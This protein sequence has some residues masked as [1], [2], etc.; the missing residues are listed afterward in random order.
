MRAPDAR[1]VSE[2]LGFEKPERRA[3]V[4]ERRAAVAWLGCEQEAQRAEDENRRSACHNEGRRG[5]KE[6]QADRTATGS[7]EAYRVHL[8]ALGKAIA[9]ERALREDFKPSQRE[10][11][12]WAWLALLEQHYTNSG[13]ALRRW[14]RSRAAAGRRRASSHAG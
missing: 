7:M 2:T 3:A 1:A 9:A 8:S 5:K 12:S 4:E 14:R 13:D 10:E 6:R 11:R